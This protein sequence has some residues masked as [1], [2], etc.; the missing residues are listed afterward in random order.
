MGWN[1]GPGKGTEVPI[2]ASE[3]LNRQTG[4][5]VYMSDGYANLYT[6]TTATKAAGTIMG[7]AE[8]PK[9]DALKNGYK[10][11]SGDNVFVITGLEDKFW[12]PADTAEASVVAS[13][14]GVGAGI[15]TANA[16]YALTQKAVPAVVDASA[17]LLIHDIDADNDAVL[18][19]MK[20]G[21][22]MV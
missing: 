4:H 12:M 10:A 13:L 9:D 21:A 5:F 19:S 3:Y 2:K 8:A 15:K 11:S 17:M 7:W 20:P 16:T 22:Y 14:I 18:V 6:C 1:S